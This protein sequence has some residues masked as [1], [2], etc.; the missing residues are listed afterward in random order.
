MEVTEK[1]KKLYYEEHLKQVDI[2]RSLDVSKQYISKVIKEDIR[3]NEE[4]IYRKNENAK[5]RKEKLVEYHKNYNRKKVKD[6]SYEQLQALLNQD[7]RI[8]SSTSEISNY[9]YAKWNRSAFYR[10]KQGHLRLKSNINAGYNIP[11]TVYCS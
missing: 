5:N 11:K 8:L 6:N 7:T 9:S 4:K 1:I 3:Y 2:S 10:T